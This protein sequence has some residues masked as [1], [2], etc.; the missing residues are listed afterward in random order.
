MLFHQCFIKHSN[1]GPNSLEI[2]GTGSRTSFEIPDYLVYFAEKVTFISVDWV[3]QSSN[4]CTACT[5][6]RSEVLTQYFNDV[7]IKFIDLT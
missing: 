7:M 3:P 6:H 5:V 1:N 4:S 2:S